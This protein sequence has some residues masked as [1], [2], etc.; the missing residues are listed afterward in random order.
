MAGV[1][2]EF[3]VP[4]V[5]LVQEP[6]GAGIVPVGLSVTALQDLLQATA[7]V[8]RLLTVSTPA[9]TPDPTLALAADTL[10]HGAVVTHSAELSLMAAFRF[11]AEAVA[12][13][14]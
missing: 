5:E 3:S 7:L 10:K 14:P 9:E 6:E 11:P 4:A 8:V 1:V 12:F 13:A 2:L